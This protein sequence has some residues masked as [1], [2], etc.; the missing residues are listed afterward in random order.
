MEKL[1]IAPNEISSSTTNVFI[2]E[3]EKYDLYFF[4]TYPKMLSAED[5]TSVRLKHE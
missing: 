5:K 3:N 1:Q 2:A 4:P